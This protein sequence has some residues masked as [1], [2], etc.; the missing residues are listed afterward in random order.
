MLGGV[1]RGKLV[2]LRVPVEADL[3]AHQRWAAELGLRRAGWRWHEPAALSTWSERLS[4]AAKDRHLV[5]WSIDEGERIVGCARLSSGNESPD[6][7]SG[8]QVLIDPADQGRGLG[9][10]AARALHRYLFDYLTTRF[11]LCALPADQAAA[12]HVADRLGYREFARG[13]D[14][15]YRDGAYTD[16]LQLKLDRETWTE[17]WAATEREYAPTA[18]GAER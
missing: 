7:V 14:V 8:V 13:H 1:V 16:E 11:A 4:E 15:F 9:G 10:D 18:P 12:L 6:T 17:R 3:A 2:T 5:L